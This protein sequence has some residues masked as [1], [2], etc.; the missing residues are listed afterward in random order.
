MHE[1]HTEECRIFRAYNSPCIYS[2]FLNLDNTVFHVVAF[3]A[4]IRETP[5]ALSSCETQN[6]SRY[7]QHRCPHLR[8]FALCQSRTQVGSS[9]HGSA[10]TSL[11]G[12]HEDAGS[13][14]GLAQWVKDPVLQCNPG[15]GCKRSS[16][17]VFLWLWRW[18]L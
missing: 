7:W 3:L 6:T 4:S 13:M 1:K 2:R 18:Q 12:I 14:P 16:D 10:E 8:T 5:V 11:T 9:C 15:V 17:L